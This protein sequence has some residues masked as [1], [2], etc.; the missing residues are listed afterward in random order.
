METTALT[1]FVCFKKN[2]ELDNS[3][4]QLG[5]PLDTSSRNSA[6]E[7]A[8]AAEYLRKSATSSSCLSRKLSSARSSASAR[9]NSFFLP[10]WSAR[11]LCPRRGAHVCVRK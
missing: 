3:E 10:F 11:A 7:R 2:L 4:T 8:L 5:L 6:N 1:T 9:R